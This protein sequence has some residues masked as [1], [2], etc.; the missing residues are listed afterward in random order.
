MV[1]SDFGN[2]SWF[3]VL[4]TIQNSFY[5]KEN[6]RTRIFKYTVIKEKADNDV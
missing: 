2:N 6:N 1:A 4:D 5:D 3:G